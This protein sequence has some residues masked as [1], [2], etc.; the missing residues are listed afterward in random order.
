[1]TEVIMRD[2]GSSTMCKMDGAFD[3]GPVVNMALVSRL[4]NPISIAD[5]E[6]ST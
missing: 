6:F 2:P 4:P 5:V 3:P 1:M